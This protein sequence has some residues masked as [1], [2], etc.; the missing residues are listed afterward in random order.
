MKLT[1]KVKT[2]DY[3]FRL[4]HSDK[5][6]LL[7]SCFSNNMGSMLRQSGFRA[8]SNPA[9]IQFNPYSLLEIT[10]RAFHGQYVQE[11]EL[12]NSGNVNFHWS[13]QKEFCEKEAELS[14]IKMNRALEELQEALNGLRV[15]CITLG[16]SWVYRH[17]SED[18]IV[19]N[20]HKQDAEFFE[21]MLLKPKDICII[22]DEMIQMIRGASPDCQIILTTSPIRHEKDGLIENNRSKSHLLAAT[23]TICEQYDYC[24]YFPSY[25]IM[26]DELRDYRFYERDMLHPSELAIEYVFSRFS[27]ALLD[28]S[29]RS[30]MILYKKL[31]RLKNHKVINQDSEEYEKYLEAMR[32]LETEINSRG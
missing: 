4:N 27:E 1:T 17:K 15:C 21:K 24:Q 9:G 16:T 11:T 22:L 25:E 28:E 10:R 32:K 20:C 30:K 29:C 13:F 19:A 14:A 12:R 2:P 6:L 5:I 31:H 23:H 8:L 3:A 26:M 18:M 7:G